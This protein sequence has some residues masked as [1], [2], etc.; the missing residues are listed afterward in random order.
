MDP[1]ERALRL[2]FGLRFAI[3]TDRE[4]RTLGTE[5]SLCSSHHGRWPR[6]KW[7]RIAWRWELGL[8]GGRLDNWRRLL[9][10]EGK[11]SMSWWDRGQMARRHACSFVWLNGNWISISCGSMLSNLIMAYSPVA[12]LLSRN[13][14]RISGSIDRITFGSSKLD[15]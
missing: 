13:W 7:F 14:R 6:D 12:G 10:D 2:W 4:R 5:L 9:E 11:V 15:V 8:L 3:L 1:Q